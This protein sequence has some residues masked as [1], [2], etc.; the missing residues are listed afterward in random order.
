M[1]ADLY[2]YRSYILQ[3]SLADVRYR[4]AGST[5]GVFWNVLQPL[6]LILVFSIVFGSVFKERG[7][8][9]E[10]PG[11]F[12]IYLV[13]ALLPWQAFSE[14]LSR[15]A[16]AF[17]HNARYLRK[18]PIPE[19]VFSAQ[20]ATSAAIGLAMSYGVFMLVAIA[21]RHWPTWHWLLLPLPL[22]S[23][24]V[25][26]FGL[27]LALGTMNVFIRDIGELIGIVLMVG[28]WA[29]PVVYPPE[30]L[31]QWAQN[32]L[33]L[34]PVYPMLTSARLLFLYGEMPGPG[35]IAGMIAWP[36]AAGLAGWLALRTLGGEIRDVL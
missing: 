14:C 33:P 8:G 24:C 30:I 17:I 20:T 25:L 35:L 21:L 3:T 12:A 11:G 1:L 4:Y 31:P 13:S 9:V 7:A 32:A 16:R 26:G 10:A 2:R 29:Y 34:N 18:L 27:G 15:G 6:A 36:A 23:L 19:V 22:L 5:V 28:F